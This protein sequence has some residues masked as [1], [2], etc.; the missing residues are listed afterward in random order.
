MEESLDKLDK[1]IL[2][3]VQNDSTPSVKEIGD[4]IGLS[5]TPTYERIKRLE[6]DGVIAKYVALVDR[7]KV[8][9]NLIAYCNIVLKEQ[10]K[11]A[12]ADF[13]KYVSKIPEIMEVTSV[14]GPYNYMLKIVVT[15]IKSYND[16]VTNTLADIPNIRQHFSNIVLNEIKKVTTFKFP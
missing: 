4:K 15:D 12:S 11:K 2:N 14:S 13:E 3:I 10:S 9:L 16:F 8:G 1:A 6:K 7:K 5:T